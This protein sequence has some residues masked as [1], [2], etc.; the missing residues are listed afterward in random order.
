MSDIELK[1]GVQKTGIIKSFLL[2]LPVIFLSYFLLGQGKAGFHG[3]TLRAIAFTAGYL[4]INILFFLMIRSGQTYKYRKI[5]F[6][7]YA[8]LFIITF[9][10]NII[11]VR[12]SI[13]LNQGNIISGETPFCHIVIPMTIIPAALTKT[14]IFPGSILKG[15][16][17]IATMFIIWIG[18]TIAFGRAWCSWACFYGGLDEGFSCLCRKPR[19]KISKKWLILPFAVLVAVVLLSAATLSP[20][21]CEW[22]CP[23]KAVT[24]FDAIVSVKTLVAAVLFYSLFVIL[25]VVLP[26]L[27]GKRT[28]C[29]LFCPFGA[30]QSFTNKINIFEVRIDTAK[31]IGC[32]KCIREC[33][34]YSIDEES[35]AKG[36]TTITCTKCARCIDLCPAHA[37]SY[38]IKGTPI[39]IRKDAAR[40]LFLYAVYL[41]ALTIAGGAVITGI[42]RILKLVTT[43]SFF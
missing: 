19:I 35:L 12:G 42:Y 2:C 17:S 18:A 13:L 37:V 38:H 33:P 11:E 7:V 3:D 43:G 25:V 29:A 36:K 24:E 27:S 5:F 32:K 23:F 1:K 9:M 39:G 20:V 21:Y 30:M 40:T 6:V 41:F 34:T 16:A 4:S 26:I 22:L 8:L 28:Q 14:I 10:T 15:W 31:C